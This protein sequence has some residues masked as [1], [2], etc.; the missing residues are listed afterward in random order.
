MYGLVVRK[1]ARIAQ[2]M[3]EQHRV[4]SWNFTGVRF[5]GREES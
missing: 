5:N 4:N 2:K 1:I 3:P